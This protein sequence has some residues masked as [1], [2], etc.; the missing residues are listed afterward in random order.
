MTSSIGLVVFPAAACVTPVAVFAKV[1]EEV[2][3]EARAR[4]PPAVPV[5]SVPFKADFPKVPVPAREPTG[6]FS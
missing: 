6:F 4:N 5:A 2:A 1:D 3:A